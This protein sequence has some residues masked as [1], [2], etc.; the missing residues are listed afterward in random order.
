MFVFTAGSEAIPDADEEYEEEDVADKEKYADHL[1][2]IGTLGRE[3][4]EHS[5][6]TLAR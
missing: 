3:V 5:L 2:S 4:I 1:M 6:P